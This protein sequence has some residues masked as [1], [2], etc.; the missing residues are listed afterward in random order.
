[1]DRK[2][3]LRTC[4]AIALGGTAIVPVLQGCA[5]GIHYAAAKVDG[6]IVTLARSEFIDIDGSGTDTHPFVLVKVPSQHRPICVYRKGPDAFTA[7][8]TVCTHQGCEVRPNK[9]YLACPCHGSEFS[10]TGEVLHGPAELSLRSYPV[11]LDNENVY[12]HL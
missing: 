5:A 6:A 9:E 2:S 10:T 8:S 3:F 11:T 4:A 7:L 12:I 1:M